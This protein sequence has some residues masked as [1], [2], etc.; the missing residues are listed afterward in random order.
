[1][2]HSQWDMLSILCKQGRWAQ[3]CLGASEVIS[4]FPSPISLPWLWV[5]VCTCSSVVQWEKTQYGQASEFQD[6]CLG[7]RDAGDNVSFSESRITALGLQVSYTPPFTSTPFHTERNTVA[8]ELRENLLINSHCSCTNI[9][10]PSAA[11]LHN[12][13]LISLDWF[14]SAHG[15][16]TGE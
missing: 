16:P 3:F 13:W 6:L 2:R 9:F 14:W 11:L 10:F 7:K 1:M 12:Y 5:S 15:L 4:G 8:E